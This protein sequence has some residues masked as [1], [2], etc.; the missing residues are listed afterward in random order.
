ME[1]NKV[2]IAKKKKDVYMTVVPN[3]VFVRHLIFHMVFVSTTMY[4]LCVCVCV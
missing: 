2:A 3:R 4:V 1:S